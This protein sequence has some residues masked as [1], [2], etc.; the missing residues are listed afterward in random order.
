[1]DTKELLKDGLQTLGIEADEQICD[2]FM[3]YKDLLLEWNQKMNLTAITEDRD[4]IIKHFLDSASVFN[5]VKIKPG[6]C[7]IDV[8]SGAG[9]PGI[10]FKLLQPDADMLLLDSLKKRLNFL[11]EV[12]KELGLEKIK[13]VHMRAEDAGRDINYRGKFDLCVSRAVARLAV[14]AEYC[15]PLVKI[16][17]DFVAMKGPNVAQEISEA[18]IAVET[19]GGEIVDVKTVLLPHSD[20]NHTFIVIKKI[21]QTSKKYPR[22]AALISKT[23]IE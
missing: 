18:E 11:D 21:R 19:L 20:I 10:P 13:T 16:G 2:K 7:V 17:G 1:L 12:I 14:L 3:L 4:V 6:M 8:G 22:I 15:L 9:F 23:P 5:A